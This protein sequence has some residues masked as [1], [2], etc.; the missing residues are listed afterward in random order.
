MI[1]DIR[2]SYLEYLIKAAVLRNSPAAY[3]TTIHFTPATP[4]ARISPQ[5]TR[6]TTSRPPSSWALQLRVAPPTNVKTNA[7]TMVTVASMVVGAVFES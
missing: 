2:F 5:A 3:H 1:S 6:A 7:E 4:T